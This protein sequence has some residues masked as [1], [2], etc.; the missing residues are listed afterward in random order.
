MI[1]GSARIGRSSIFTD[2]IYLSMSKNGDARVASVD[3]N[4]S[5]NLVSI[6]VSAD[7][8]LNTRADF[9]GLLWTLAAG[10]TVHETDTSSV[11]LFAGVRLFSSD[12]T[13]SWDLSASVATPGGVELLA[14]QGSIGN[15][16]DLWDG[17]LGV[18]GHFR[19]G[20]GNWSVPYY[21]DVGAGFRF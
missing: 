11:D 6:P 7:L 16:T 15:D 13:A 10:Y 21:I 17:I 14:A 1:G 4:V 3:G 2:V 20:D 19:F 9:D 18:R 12:F 8:T 5:G